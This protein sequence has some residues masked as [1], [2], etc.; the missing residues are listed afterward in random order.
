MFALALHIAGVYIF[1]LPPQLSHHL[2]CREGAPSK[3]KFL[4]STEFPTTSLYFLSQFQTST[5]DSERERERIVKEK[6][7][8]FTNC[9][10]LL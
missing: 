8:E 5:E 2:A 6:T 7:T 9:V 3:I 4:G 10:V 1:S